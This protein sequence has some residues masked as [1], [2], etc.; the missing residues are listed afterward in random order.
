[1]TATAQLEDI[2]RASRHQLPAGPDE[3]EI[4]GDILCGVDGTRTAYEAVRQAASLLAPGGRLTVL[5]VAE[6]TGHGLPPARARGRRPARA[7][8]SASAQ[9]A[10]ITPVHARSVLE[11]SRRL[12][13]EAGVRATVELDTEGPV[14]RVLLKRAGEHRLLALGA[15]AMSRHAHIVIGG[16]AS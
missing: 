6:H 8:A 10:Q 15:P 13:R 14:R 5:M 4:L 2:A 9:P 3:P 16:V 1:M 7:G 12:A 11:Y